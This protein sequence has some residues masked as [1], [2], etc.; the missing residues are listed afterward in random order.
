M[1]AL[2]NIF[3]V[4]LKEF[5]KESFRENGRPEEIRLRIG[6]PV[7]LDNGSRER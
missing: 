7:V 1:E 5:I 2:W 4:H 3:P 6:Q